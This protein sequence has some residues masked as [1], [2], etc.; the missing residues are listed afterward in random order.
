MTSS[1]LMAL[2]LILP[3]VGAVLIARDG[4]LALSRGYG[5]EV[6]GRSIDASTNPA[7]PST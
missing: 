7:S 1:T 2:A 6:A 5:E 3:L 4:E